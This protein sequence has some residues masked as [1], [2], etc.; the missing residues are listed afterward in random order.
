MQGGY[1][2][3]LIASL[4][5]FAMLTWRKGRAMLAER[6]QNTTLPIDLFLASIAEEKPL[7]V[8]GTAVFMTSNNG[9]PHSLIHYFKHA[10]SL[11]QRI[12]FLTVRT[13]HVPSVPEQQ[14]IVDVIDYGSGIF[15]ATVALG[16]METPDI[17]QQLAARVRLFPSAAGSGDRARHSN[18]DVTRPQRAQPSAEPEPL[19]N[20][21]LT[22]NGPSSWY[23]T[24]T[25]LHH[26]TRL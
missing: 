18:R 4:V 10:K 24:R 14:R 23:S 17:Q 26:P 12:V 8:P 2:T 9:A 6:L 21:R 7:R 20:W 16:F 5:A 25:I 19:T 3:I 11:H 13:K 15:G 1:V 22:G